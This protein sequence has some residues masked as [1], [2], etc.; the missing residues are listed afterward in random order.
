[1]ILKNHISLTELAKKIKRSKSAL[2]VNYI[3]KT[4]SVGG[5]SFIDMDDIRTEH[6]EAAKQCLDYSDFLPLTFLADYVLGVHPQTI[7][8]RIRF[9]IQTNKQMYEAHHI[10]YRW[11][12]KLPKE[13]IDKLE[14]KNI[15]IAVKNLRLFSDYSSIS[16]YIVWGDLIIAFY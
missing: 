3:N 13:L 7:R 16:D 10:H 2:H 11:F 12:I 1:M 8:D 5:I 9:G 14:Q 4:F 6:L 15:P